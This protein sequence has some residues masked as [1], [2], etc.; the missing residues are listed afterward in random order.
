MSL[1]KD[2]QKY[3][4]DPLFK[5]LQGE[6]Y[7][8]FPVMTKRGLFR[9]EIDKN[10]MYHVYFYGGLREILTTIYMKS[11]KKLNRHLICSDNYLHSKMNTM[12]FKKACYHIKD[13]IK[14]IEYYYNQV[15]MALPFV[16]ELKRLIMACL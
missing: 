12:K 4:I 9:I 5:N 14:Y 10:N 13:R 15:Y 6:N 8:W 16:P 3:F 1:I 7:K 2:K 11:Q